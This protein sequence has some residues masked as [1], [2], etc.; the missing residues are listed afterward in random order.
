MRSNV[1]EIEKEVAYI[2]DTTDID[3]ISVFLDCP[4]A[5][6]VGLITDY[7]IQRQTRVRS[8]QNPSGSKKYLLTKKTGEKISGSRLE[9]ETPI[10]ENQFDILKNMSTLKVKKHRYRLQ[11]NMHPCIDHNVYVDIVLEPLGV[12]IVE[13]EYYSDRKLTSKQL[14]DK[15][16]TICPFSAYDFFRRK[17]GICGSESSGKTET[18][19]TISGKINTTL[20]G[21]AF[22][23]SEYCTSFIQEL[24]DTPV[25]AD[26]FLIFNEQ[27]KREA[28]A[29]RKSNIVI[30]D[31]PTFLA[32]IYLGTHLDISEWERNKIHMEK[33]YGYVLDDIQSYSQIIHL[34]P[35]KYKENN[36][37]YHG[38]KKIEH[39]D[40][41]INNF[42]TFHKIDHLQCTYEDIDMIMQHLFYTN[43]VV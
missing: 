29:W 40:S 4:V 9:N 37:R 2:L 24:N 14:F 27:R 20:D 28:F 19:K 16:L 30:S 38:N 35:L 3:K 26:T 17:I 1:T 11:D 22:Y 36:I 13:I 43:R 5:E 32:Y 10:T 15:E 31:S 42:L 8:I 18:A 7:Y 25:F 21:N 6:D 41:Q 12:S 23:V 39:I 33:L 34:K